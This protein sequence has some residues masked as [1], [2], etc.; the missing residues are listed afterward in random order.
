MAHKTQGG[1]TI[2][3][4]N[5]KPYYYHQWYEDGKKKSQITMLV[6]CL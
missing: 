5:G 4:I 6:Q 3:K 2:K 1:V